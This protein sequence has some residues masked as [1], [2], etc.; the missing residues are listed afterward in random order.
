M[1]IYQFLFHNKDR[2]NLGQALVNSTGNLDFLKNLKNFD[3]ELHGT[4]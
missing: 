4:C 1:K 2:K 3:K